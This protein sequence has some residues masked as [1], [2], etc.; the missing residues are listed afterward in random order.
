MS[1]IGNVDSFL[2]PPQ[3]PDPTVLEFFLWGNLKIF[4]HRGV[5]AFQT[6]IVARLHAACSTLLP[7]VHSSILRHAQARL[8]MHGGHFPV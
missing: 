6:E 5:V 4:V 1:Q 7:L 2:W 3:S 8:D